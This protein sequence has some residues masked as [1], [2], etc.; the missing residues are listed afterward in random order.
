M[1]HDMKFCEMRLFWVWNLI[2]NSLPIIAITLSNAPRCGMIRLESTK[3]IALRR[4]ISLITVL[5]SQ[6]RN[7][8]RFLT[9]KILTLLFVIKMILIKLIIKLNHSWGETFPSFQCDT[10]FQNIKIFRIMNIVYIIYS[11]Y[12]T[13]Q[14]EKR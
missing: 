4:S 7:S 1:W 12:Y 2:F 3:N 11:S 14:I 13:E 10:H 8:P 9:A 6:C 5:T